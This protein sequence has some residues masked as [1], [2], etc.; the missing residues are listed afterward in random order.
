MENKLIAILHFLIYSDKRA[1]KAMEFNF[2][3]TLSPREDSTLGTLA[4]TRTAP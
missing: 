1:A 4:P 3:S 2:V